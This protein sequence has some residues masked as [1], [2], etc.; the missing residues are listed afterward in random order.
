MTHKIFIIV[1]TDENNGIGK[2]G[3]MPWDLKDELRHFQ[4]ITTKTTDPD[5]QNMVIMGSTTW[6]SIPSK[7]RPLKNRKNVVL[8]RDSDFEA[9]GATVSSSIEEALF[10]ADGTVENIFIIGGASV[11]RQAIEKDIAD[12]IYLTR[13]HEEYECDT[14]F[15]EIPEQFGEP[16]NLG[17]GE[18]DDISYNYLLYSK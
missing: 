5:K 10:L 8:A 2:N 3:K 17:G 4:E 16:M 1:A 13:I 9:E 15:P 11:Y 14:F 18:E 7:H 12:G 6:R